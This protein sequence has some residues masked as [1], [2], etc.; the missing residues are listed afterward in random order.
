MHCVNGGLWEHSVECRFC[1]RR[2]SN[3]AAL[4]SGVESQRTKRDHSEN[5]FPVPHKFTHE[6]EEAASDEFLAKLSCR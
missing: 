3:R 4:D 2:K 6:C 1:V 5:A